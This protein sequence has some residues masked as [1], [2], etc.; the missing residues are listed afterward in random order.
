MKAI[1]MDLEFDVLSLE[2]NKYSTKRYLLIQFLYMFSLHFLPIEKTPWLGYCRER[3]AQRMELLGN[4]LHAQ[5]R[6]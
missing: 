1:C 5:G 3:H 6:Q 2:C 4:T